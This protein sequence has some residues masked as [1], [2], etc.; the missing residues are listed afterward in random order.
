MFPGPSL[1]TLLSIL[2]ANP[3]LA[4]ALD[5]TSLTRFI[6][7]ISLLKPFLL[8]LQPSH[9]TNPP[10]QLSVNVHEFL[11]VSMEFDDDLTKLA[12]EAL[13]EIAW[14]FDPD[15]EA[16]VRHLEQESRVQL[17]I[18]IHS[19]AV[20]VFMQDF[21]PI[22]GQSTS[23]YCHCEHLF[24]SAMNASKR[25]YYR[26]SF[27]FIQ[28]ATH[29]FTTMMA[30]AWTSATNCARIY[31]EGI[32]VH[33]LTPSLP[34]AY[35][36]SLKL[37]AEDVWNSLFLYWLLLDCQ[38]QGTILELDHK[39]GSQAHRLEPALQACNLQI[40]GTG[41]EEWSHACDACCWINDTDP[42]QIG[43][44][45]SVIID[46]INT[47]GCPCCDIHDCVVPLASQNDHFSPDHNDLADECTVTSCTAKANDGYRTCSLPSHCQLE[48][49]KD[50]QNK[51]MF[52]LKHRLAHLKL[53]Q[54]DPSSN[55]SDSL[56]N[57]AHASLPYSDEP[58]LID[59][60]ELCV[61]SCGVILGHATFYGSETPNGTF[62]MWLFP[63]KS[64]L[65]GV[66]WHD[67]NCQIQAMLQAEEDPYL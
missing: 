67:N 5:I 36:K 16:C 51:A 41:Q 55:L 33:K 6:Q 2:V 1:E 14:D 40:L 65:P 26:G 19:V 59:V 27:N 42:E 31:N 23:M 30:H 37:D 61:A 66:I 12:W 62:L 4:K 52:Q 21:G 18:L 17:N 32:G 50:E 44:V 8:T 56:D 53:S 39:A 35:S 63:M 60:N 11:K 58:V 49:Y 43:C 29:L 24:H 20:T 13:Q 3:H 22:P 57:A 34:D 54:P 47:I 9:N 7:I 15:I 46:G 10:E 28:I 38:E 25:T 48:S 45:H 64:S